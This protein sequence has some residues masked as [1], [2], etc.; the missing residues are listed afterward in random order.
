MQH[1]KRYDQVDW[2]QG[3]GTIGSGVG[4][5][6]IGF[7]GHSTYCSR[8]KRTAYFISSRFESNG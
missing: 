7:S 4:R 3:H 1:V 5:F 2:S 6:G 8:S